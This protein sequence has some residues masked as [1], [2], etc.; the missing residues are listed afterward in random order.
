MRKSYNKREKNRLLKE[1]TEKKWLVK[2]LKKE[3]KKYKK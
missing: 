1:H 3:L 2:L